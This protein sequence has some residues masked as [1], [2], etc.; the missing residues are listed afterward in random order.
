M[1]TELV[2]M[3]LKDM[4][5]VHPAQDD[6]KVCSKCGAPVGI[7]PSGQRALRNN[8]A[9]KIVCSVCAFATPGT[10]LD[11]VQPVGSLGEMWQESRD[12]LDATKTK[13]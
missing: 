2:T 8:P 5:R 3:R 11:V 13:S 4:T 7:Y 6:T 1:P 12:S 10:S 9:I